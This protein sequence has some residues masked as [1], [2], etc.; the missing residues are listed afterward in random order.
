MNLRLYIGQKYG[1]WFT[2]VIGQEIL[3]KDPDFL[4]FGTSWNSRSPSHRAT[5]CLPELPLTPESGSPSLPWV[6]TL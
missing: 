3:H 4:I 2:M 1:E 6:P 5:H